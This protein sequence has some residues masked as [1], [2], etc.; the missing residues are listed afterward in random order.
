MNIE[1]QKL[2][3]RLNTKDIEALT[4]KHRA[5]I[6]RWIKAGKFPQPQYINGQRSWRE[7]AIAE[8][9]ASCP[10]VIRNKGQTDATE[11]SRRRPRTSRK[12]V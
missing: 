10:S 3:R 7:D 11:Q 9:D 1:T 6:W 5:T 2:A 8:W 4:G 12:R